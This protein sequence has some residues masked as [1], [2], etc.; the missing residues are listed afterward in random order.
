M[1]AWRARIEEG[2][3]QSKA[4]GGAIAV[5]LLAAVLMVLGTMNWKPHKPPVITGMQIEAVMV[6]TQALI[7]KRE[8][9]IREAE[10]ARQ[11]EIARE[12]RQRE[13]EAQ[14]ERERVAR[15]RAAAEE[16]ERQPNSHF[17]LPT[18]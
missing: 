7:E 2:W 18:T 3:A 6:D 15:E 11:R 14:R 4:F 10:Q 12:Q 13:L 17:P 8:A 1:T 9:A 16:A 5:H